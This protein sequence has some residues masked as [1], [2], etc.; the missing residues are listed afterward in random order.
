MKNDCCSSLPFPPLCVMW[1]LHV[2]A[3]TTIGKG[4]QGVMKRWGF[5]GQPASHGNS[6]AHR[7]AGSI[8][9]CQ[10]PGKVWKGKKM[11][12][13]MGGDLRTV[14]NSWLYKVWGAPVLINDPGGMGSVSLPLLVFRGHAIPG[15]K[16]FD[17]S[18]E[19]NC[20]EPCP[21]RS[22]MLEKLFTGVISGLCY[23]SLSV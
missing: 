7:A 17:F 19:Q 16:I 22:F 10:D 6:L 18:W 13:R 20:H 1:I 15:I 11:P 8:G 5:K 2:R 4:F 3:G 12:G 21:V 23:S 14:L 9:A